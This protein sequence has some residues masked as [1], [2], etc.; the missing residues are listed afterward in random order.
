LIDIGIAGEHFVLTAEAQGLGTCWIGWFKEK[1]IKKLLSIPRSVK[2]LSL[3]SL[4]FPA[5]KRDPGKRLPYES[6]C[7]SETWT[8]SEKT[9]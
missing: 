1:P 7:F 5:E 8:D 2:V 3:L 6:V 9:T 4:G